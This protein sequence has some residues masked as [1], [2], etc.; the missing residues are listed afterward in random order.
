MS[1]LNRRAGTAL[2]QGN[3]ITKGWKRALFDFGIELRGM[4]NF[5]ADV[6]LYTFGRLSAHSC[7]PNRGFESMAT[8][9]C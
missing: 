3:L 1:L 8:K 9:A 5:P 4:A 6:V 2:D 7:W